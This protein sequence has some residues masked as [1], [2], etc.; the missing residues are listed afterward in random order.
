MRVCCY[1][2]GVGVGWFDNRMLW[3]SI[4]KLGCCGV[5]CLYF[6]VYICVWTLVCL[7]WCIDSRLMYTRVH[8]SS[9]YKTLLSL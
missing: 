5:F 7:N 1:V 6:G 9:F 2:G 8:Q 3:W 4:L